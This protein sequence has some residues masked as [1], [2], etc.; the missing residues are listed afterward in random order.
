LIYHLIILA[1]DREDIIFIIGIVGKIG[2]GKTTVASGLEKLLPNSRVIDVD[3]LAKGLY[4]SKPELLKDIRRDLGEEVFNNGQ[5]DLKALA[6]EVF[7]SKA[8]LT[9]L[10][11]IMFPAI[12]REVKEQVDASQDLDY[13]IIDAAILFS[14][15]L[16]LLCHYV[17]WVKSPPRYRKKFLI[18]L[19]MPEEE[20]QLKIKGQK[21]RIDRSLVDFTLENT[22]SEKRL[23]SG[24][25]NLAQDIILR[26]SSHGSQV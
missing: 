17:V 16:N 10:N 23:W 7:G 11:R 25:E 12:R 6:L 5:L 24:I 19:G 13:L 2:A 8:Q 14:C 3:G 15:K 21:I 20:A 1:G 22:R 18:S 4:E 26:S 9:K